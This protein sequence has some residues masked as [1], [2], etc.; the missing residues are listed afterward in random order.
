MLHY[1]HQPHPSTNSKPLNLTLHK[2]RKRQ[3]RIY[4]NI[5]LIT[6]IT[7]AS[8]EIADGRHLRKLFL[9]SSI[10]SKLVSKLPYILTMQRQKSQIPC[11]QKIALVQ[12][13][14]RKRFQQPWKAPRSLLLVGE[15]LKAMWSFSILTI[16]KM[17]PGQSYVG[18]QKTGRTRGIYQWRI[19]LRSKS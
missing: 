10:Q 9:P 11:L 14:R 12:W 5:T 8:K 2:M 1:P 4:Q 16:W 3:R 18:L 13:W 7:G 17:P 19:L 15:G 6:P